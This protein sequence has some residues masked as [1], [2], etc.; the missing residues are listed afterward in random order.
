M[1]L[2]EQVVMVV[3]VVLVETMDQ[4]RQVALALMVEVMVV[5]ELVV[6]TIKM[7]EMV[8]QVQ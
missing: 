5:V 6:E 8:S 7:V 3:E 4:P 1:D 2:P